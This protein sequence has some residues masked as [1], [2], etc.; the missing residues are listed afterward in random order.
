MP[1]PATKKKLPKYSKASTMNLS[2]Y[3]E[4][5]RFWLLLKMELF[6]SR[7]GFLLT[8]GVTFGLLFTGFVLENIFGTAKVYDSHRTSYAF[9]LLIGGFILSS[10]AFNDL[11]N[12]LR[13]SNYLTLPAST[14]EKFISMWLLT[15]ICWIILFTLTFIIYALIANSAGHLFFRRMTFLSFEPLARIPI[16]TIRYYIIFQTVFLV[17]AVHFRGYVF[18]KTIFALMLFA[19][20]C[21][22][23]FYVIMADIIHSDVECPA[24]FNPLQE[25]P[26][27]QIWLGI[28]WWVWWVLAPLGWI[29]TYIGLKDLEV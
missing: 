10:L 3:F 17:G 22:I 25:G 26:M 5:S 28:K 6:R 29:I 19:M 11:S 21:G 18:P 7:K 8:F 9:F 27:V 20:A 24:G 13:R 2:N 15:C 4:P 1:S 14:Y 12:P 16:Q 23:T